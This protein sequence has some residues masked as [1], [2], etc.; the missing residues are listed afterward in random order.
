[1]A[2][3]G[4]RG[5]SRRPSS[6]PPCASRKARCGASLLTSSSRQRFTRAS[7]ISDFLTK[8]LLHV[9]SF[10]QFRKMNHSIATNHDHLPP[11]PEPDGLLCARPGPDDSPGR[12]DSTPPRGWAPGADTPAFPPGLHPAHLLGRDGSSPDDRPAAYHGPKSCSLTMHAS[13]RLNY[14][15]RDDLNPRRPKGG[16]HPIWCR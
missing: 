15:L 13:A 12:P 5:R 1:M 9:C 4:V 14:P 6:R 16:S 7:Q 11:P 2:I 3:T 10:N 8:A